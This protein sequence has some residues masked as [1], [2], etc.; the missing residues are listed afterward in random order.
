MTYGTF[1]C[2]K[3]SGVHREMNNKV[4]GIGVS[5]FTEQELNTLN[6]MGNDVVFNNLE[7]KGYMDG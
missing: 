2:S 1:V 7:S 5:N 3:C 4:K 6:N